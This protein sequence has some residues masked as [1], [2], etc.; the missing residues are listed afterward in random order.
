MELAPPCGYIQRQQHK[1]RRRGT[2]I[3]YLHGWQEERTRSGVRGSHIYR[4]GTHG[5]TH[6]QPRQ[7]VF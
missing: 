6:I 5:T 1:R 4:K 3:A 2:P 7:Q